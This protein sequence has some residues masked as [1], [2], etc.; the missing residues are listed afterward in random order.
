M[1]AEPLGQPNQRLLVPIAAR[2][3][4]ALETDGSGA[5]VSSC[6]LLLPHLRP[7]QAGFH[8]S[9]LFKFPEPALRRGHDLDEATRAALVYAIIARSLGKDFDAGVSLIALRVRFRPALL[10]S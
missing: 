2:A 9:L 6:Y 7:S 3:A 1:H 4:F 5:V 8:L 10:A